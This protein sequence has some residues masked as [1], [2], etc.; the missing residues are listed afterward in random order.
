ME[1]I[2]R[3]NRHAPVVMKV[4]PIHDPKLL[5]I[6]SIGKKK[7][8][9]NSGSGMGFGFVVD[10]AGKEGLMP[11][12]AYTPTALSDRDGQ[13]DAADRLSQT[14]PATETNVIIEGGAEGE[15]LMT[16]ELHFPKPQ[17]QG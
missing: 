5:I 11:V 2:I 13:D 7:G 1:T 16:L 8:K 4:S 9:P 6:E 10:E 14:A 15:I 3:A 12:S 17:M